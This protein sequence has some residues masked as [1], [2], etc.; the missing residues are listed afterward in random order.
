LSAIS[1]SSGYEERV[2]DFLD[3]FAAALL[4]RGRVHDASKLAD[5]EKAG[6]DR[7]TPNLKNL[8]FG[9]DDY[10][11]SLARLGD[12][13]Q[14]H[15]ASNTHHPEHWPNGVAGMDLLDLVEMFCDWRA[16]AER[17]ANKT[18][19][20]QMCVERFKIEPQLASILANSLSNKGGNRE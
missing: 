16:A 17:N 3:E 11:A 9:S 2:R 15:Y 14:H 12:S 10:K 7:E 4:E 19:N 6:F 5:P 18:V 13:L 1:Q 20:L 8:T